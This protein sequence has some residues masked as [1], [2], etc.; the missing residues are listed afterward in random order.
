MRTSNPVQPHRGR[1]RGPRPKGA[2]DNGSLTRRY[3]DPVGWAASAACQG[4]DPELFFPVTTQG[5]ARGQAEEAKAV[6]A[7]CPV[8]Q[9]CLEFALETGQNS[10]IWGG[11]TEDERRTMRRRNLRRRVPA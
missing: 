10:G 8:R 1:P 3:A 9:P 5:P 4:L 2:E 6:C 7:Q 11:T